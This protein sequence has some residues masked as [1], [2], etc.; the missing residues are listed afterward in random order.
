MLLASTM[1]RFALFCL[2][3]GLASEIEA[4]K[5]YDHDIWLLENRY[6]LQ[7]KFDDDSIELKV[8]TRH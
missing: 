4:S 8:M 5:E 1:S 2:L 3:I 7:W 6:H